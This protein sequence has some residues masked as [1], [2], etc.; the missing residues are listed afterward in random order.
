MTSPD[1]LVE[2]P[3][4]MVFT[5]DYLTRHVVLKIYDVFHRT[6]DSGASFQPALTAKWD[7]CPQ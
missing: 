5:G 2:F 3:F 4:E 6:A 1:H 7:T